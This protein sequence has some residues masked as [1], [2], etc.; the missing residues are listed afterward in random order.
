[1][2]NRYV[3]LH[4]AQMHLLGICANGSKVRSSF[5]RTDTDSHQSSAA[6]EAVMPCAYSHEVKGVTIIT[7]S[8]LVRVVLLRLLSD[9][10]FLNS[11]YNF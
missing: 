3:C 8:R 9:F 11:N 1:M 4:G 7:N 2:L 10:F 5:K 6:I